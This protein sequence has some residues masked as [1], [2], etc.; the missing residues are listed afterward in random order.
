MIL[1]LLMHTA[2][3]IDNVN[4]NLKRKGAFYKMHL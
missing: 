3:A 4:L 1:G 2:A